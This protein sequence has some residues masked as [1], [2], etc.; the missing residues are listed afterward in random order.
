MPTSESSATKR[1]GQEEKPSPSKKLKL[2]SK[3]HVPSTEAVSNAPSTESVLNA[4]ITNF[5]LN[6]VNRAKQLMTGNSLLKE[7]NQRFKKVE[8]AKLVTDKEIL[9]LKNQVE[10]LLQVHSEVN[11]DILLL[12]SKVST[13]SVEIQKYKEQIQKVI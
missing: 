2:L 9:S 5:D 8:D 13:M 12:E 1:K 6:V 3:S 11:N 10:K 7:E 4:F